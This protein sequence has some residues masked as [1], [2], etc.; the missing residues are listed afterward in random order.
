[1][2]TSRIRRLNTSVEDGW[3]ESSRTLGRVPASPPIPDARP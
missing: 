2:T 1:M 3:R